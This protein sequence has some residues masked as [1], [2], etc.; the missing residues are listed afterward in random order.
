MKKNFLT[1]IAVA[2]AVFIGYLAKNNYDLSKKLSKLTLLTPDSSTCNICK[3]FKGSGME[4]L[5]LNMLRQMAGK[6]TSTPVIAATNNR[7]TNQLRI[8]NAAG[9]TKEDS[10]AIWFSL[11]SL[12]KFIWEIESSVC[13][14]ECNTPTNLGIRLYYARY[15]DNLQNNAQLQ[16]LSPGYANLHTVFMIP[17]YE[18]GGINMDFNPHNY[19]GNCVYD[20][21]PKSDNQFL[22]TM[23]FMPIPNS[24]TAKN[25]GDLCP[26]VCDGTSF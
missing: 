6:F 24:T 15:P 11:D 1:V 13:K 2:A 12:K 18:R 7:G 9:A 3:D 17:T 8:T 20:T 22:S 16:N 25:H 14:N 5:N 4:N 10:R 21:I 23:A 26:P 19:K